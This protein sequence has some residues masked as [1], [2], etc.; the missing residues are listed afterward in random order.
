[1]SENLRPVVMRSNRLLGATLVERNLITVEQ[2]NQA[3]ERFLQIMD[4]A[5]AGGVSLLSVLINEQQVLTESA[6]LEYLVDEMQIGLIDVRELDFNDDLKMHLQPGMCWA[7][8]TVPFDKDEDV[9]YVASAY[10]LS[11][12]VRQQWE[13][14][15]GGPIIWFGATLESISGFLEKLVA[16]RAA[17][18]GVHAG[19][20]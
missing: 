6:L 4:T 8:W 7:T 17:H 10:Y 3:T 15:L 1:M 12:A 18:S 5:A 14:Q 16:E 13:K 9:H 20:A 19:A 11:P 2:L